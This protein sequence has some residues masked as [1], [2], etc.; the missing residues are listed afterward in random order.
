[1]NEEPIK[2]EASAIPGS[3]ASDTADAM[4]EE[5][6]KIEVWHVYT[7]ARA[8]RQETAQIPAAPPWR[9]F[10]G[11]P[12]VERNFAKDERSQRLLKDLER[13]RTYLVS[14]EEVNMVNAALYLRRPLLV[15]GGPGTGKSTL[16]YSVALELN[17]GPVLRW[18][19]T[20]HATIK[21]GLYAYDAIGRLQESAPEMQP[22]PGAANAAI[23]PARDL[24]DY[25]RLG[26]LGTALLPSNR[27]RVVLI[28]EIDKS[29]IDLPNDLL[30]IFEEGEFPI[31]ELLRLRGDQRVVEVF[32]ADGDTK[33]P[34][35]QGQVR[36]CEFPLV[37]LTSNAERE[38]SPAFLRRCLRLRIQNPDK[39]KLAR[40]LMS[41]MPMDDKLSKEEQGRLL[42]T[43][44]GIVELFL[45]RRSEGEMA[46]DQLMNAVFMASGGLAALES[47]RERKELMARLLQPLS[48][49]E[50]DA[51]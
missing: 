29:D 24:G 17:L 18:N 10:D 23:R 32:P 30:N 5:P 22:T 8:P 13:A 14:Q 27:P 48:S 3:P 15:T 49:R 37:I 25:I 33:V 19:I 7:G 1:M 38:F 36:C 47:D 20:S 45:Q 28:D 11:G 16:A 31:P 51:G 50:S 42:A 26:P 2:I 4:S 6:I 44:N 21:D 39:T 41:H 12:L 43:R 34:I 46:T 9:R 35:V 40:I